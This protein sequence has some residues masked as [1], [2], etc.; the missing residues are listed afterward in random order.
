MAFT[1]TPTGWLGAGYS[2]DGTDMTI[3]L[4]SLPELTAGEADASTGDIRK[5]LFAFCAAMEAKFASLP[6]A[7]RPAKMTVVKTQGSLQGATV[8]VGFTFNFVLEIG[9]LEVAAES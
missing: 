6:Q 2:E 3:P 8:Q 9:E 1:A 5:I 4:A 7:D